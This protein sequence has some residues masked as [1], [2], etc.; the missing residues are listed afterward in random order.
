[1]FSPFSR[2]FECLTCHQSALVNTAT[3]CIIV[4]ISEAHVCLHTRDQHNETSRAK[5]IQAA[6]VL[7]IS[8]HN[9]LIIKA[10][11]LN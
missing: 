4:Q 5:Q 9:R 8:R 10:R 7:N 2:S 11:L 1:M 3:S 6:S